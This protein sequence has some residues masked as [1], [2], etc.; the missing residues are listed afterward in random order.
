MRHTMQSVLHAA[1]ALALSIGLAGSAH[2]LTL[3][4]LNAG[5]SFSTPDGT[6]TFQNFSVTTSDAFAGIDLAAIEVEALPSVGFGFKVLEF[7]APLV[8]A[9]DAIGGMRIAYDVVANSALITSVGLRFTGTAIGTGA[10]ARI[11]ETVTSPAG[12]VTLEAIRV[13]GGTQDPED[14]ADLPAGVRQIG[15]VKQITLDTSSRLGMLAQISEFEQRYAVA[16][17]PEPGAFAI[18]AASLGLV[19]TASR[20]R[21]L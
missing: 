6:L 11:F 18:F 1:A 20:R 7:D 17:I 8:V 13:A 14:V 10:S 16:P 15:V 19:V 21:W 5:A 4:E 12:A 3:A 9:G 2:A